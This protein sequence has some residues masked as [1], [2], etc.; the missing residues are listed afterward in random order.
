MREGGKEDCCFLASS[1]ASLVFAS[2]RSLKVCCDRLLANTKLASGRVL[3]P[4]GCMAAAN[5][6]VQQLGTHDQKIQNCGRIVMIR[7]FLESSSQSPERNEV[8][9]SFSDGAGRDK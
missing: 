9:G 6:K 3:F 5:M 7:I 4:K 8:S 2:D 1:E